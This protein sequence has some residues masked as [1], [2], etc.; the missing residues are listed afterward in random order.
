MIQVICGCQCGVVSDLQAINL[1]LFAE[2]NTWSCGWLGRLGK[3]LPKDRLA[4]LVVLTIFWWI[5]KHFP[6]FRIL[7]G[8]F[9]K[10]LKLS[11]WHD[12]LS[13]VVTDSQVAEEHSLQMRCPPPRCLE[14]WRVESMWACKILWLGEQIRTYTTYYYLLHPITS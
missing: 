7:Y 14:F 8:I 6:D 12:M 11:H 5:S 2:L 9:W 1:N 3:E 13:I 4:K 10:Y